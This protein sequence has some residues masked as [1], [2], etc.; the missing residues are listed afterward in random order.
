MAWKVNQN[1][2]I[3][4]LATFFGLPDYASLHDDNI[5]YIFEAGDWAK[6]YALEQGKSEAEAEEAR[7]EAE[8]EASD[9]LHSAWYDGV[10]SAANT[11]F[12][13]HGL[14]LKPKGAEERPFD[15]KIV[16]EFSWDNAA[17]KI[18][19]TLDGYGAFHF[20][21]LR[22]F[23]DS[24]PYTAKEAVL[25]H[26]HWIKQFPVVFGSYSAQHYFDKALD[27]AFR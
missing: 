26:L 8:M 13:E 20:E 5:D 9:K 27:K 21:D 14:V 7:E 12:G 1:T 19:E 10:E 17:T 25:T 4:D 15:F 3:D 22:D 16:P 6:K 18:L 2:T 11:L 23:L 24:G